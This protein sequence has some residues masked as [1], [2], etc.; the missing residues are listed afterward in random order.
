MTARKTR[1]A[2]ETLEE[3][4]LERA[5]MLQEI[6]PTRGEGPAGEEDAEGAHARRAKLARARGERC[7]KELADAV[8]AFDSV[9]SPDARARFMSKAH[10]E[11]EWQGRRFAEAAAAEVGEAQWRAEATAAGNS[12]KSAFAA[13]AG[14]IAEDW[15]AVIGRVGPEE[16]ATMRAAV[17][18]I[19]GG[20]NP[21]EALRAAVLAMPRNCRAWQRLHTI[22]A[23][24]G[25]GRA[26]GR[27]F[28]DLGYGALMG[29]P[30]P[31]ISIRAVEMSAATA[32]R[33]IDEG[34]RNGG[35]YMWAHE[36][37]GDSEIGA[38]VASARAV[39]TMG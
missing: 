17:D 8:R 21:Y 34:V 10:S 31:E 2:S 4:E 13:W 27:V 35:R 16:T 18:A 39:A 33:K 1:S 26:S 38:L 25:L 14:E 9:C 29:A 22:A 30:V 20:A 24:R 32:R 15:R 5:E 28:R 7:R 19:E 11:A 6:A 23:D 37:V 3:I 36:R 12:V